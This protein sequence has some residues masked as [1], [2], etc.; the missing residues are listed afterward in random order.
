MSGRLSL[1]IEP[2][3]QL[4]HMWMEPGAGEDP[5]ELEDEIRS[6][7]I[8]ELD[9]RF[10]ADFYPRRNICPLQSVLTLRSGWELGEVADVADNYQLDNMRWGL[11]PHGAVHP[12]IG[13]ELY[14]LPLDALGRRPL[15]D[16]LIRRHRCL[17]ITDG[18][19]TF[20]QTGSRRRAH[21]FSATSPT[22]LAMAGVWDEWISGDGQREVSSCA[23]LTTSATP[24][25][26]PYAKQQPVI[27]SG[28]FWR[29]WLLPRRDDE[30][31]DE[32]LDL[33][34]HDPR[35]ELREEVVEELRPDINRREATLVAPQQLDLLE[36][37]EQQRRERLEDHS[38]QL[39]LF[40]A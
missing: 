26:A 19:Y 32:L 13:D 40:S 12:D 35:L 8:E 1:T 11:I 7:I 38:H 14:Y 6:L 20:E 36:I 31:L 2:W 24:Q 18:F 10:G 15:L 28:E 17:V 30:A 22:L 34:R 3:A 9:E 37:L 5:F 16:R 4:A 21:R 27:L 25:I 39:A 23:I 29:D 33:L